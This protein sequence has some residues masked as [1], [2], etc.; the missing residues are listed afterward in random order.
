LNPKFHYR[1]HKGRSL[2][3]I[4][5]QMHPIHNLPS[6]FP[7]IHSNS[8]SIKK[9]KFPDEFHLSTAQRYLACSIKCLVIGLFNQLVSWSV[10][11]KLKEMTEAAICVGTE[12]T[13]AAVVSR[14]RT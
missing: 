11:Y 14:K 7:N 4:L 12:C 5:S 2:V 9:I 6:Y 3:P 1:V 8:D 13:M 10:T